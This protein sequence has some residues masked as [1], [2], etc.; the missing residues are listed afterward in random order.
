MKRTL[1]IAFAL[2]AVAL[3]ACMGDFGATSTSFVD[4]DARTPGDKTAV[5]GVPSDPSRENTPGDNSVNGAGT[6]VYEG[7]LVSPPFDALDGDND[8]DGDHVGPVP[9]STPLSPRAPERP[10]TSA[11]GGIANNDLE[12]RDDSP[13]GPT[14]DTGDPAI[15][16]PTPGGLVG[17]TAY[18]DGNNV[19]N[20]NNEGD[21]TGTEPDT[22]SGVD[23]RATIIVG[24]SGAVPADQAAAATPTPTASEALPTAAT[25][26]DYADGREAAILDA[27]RRDGRFTTLLRAFTQT[28]VP[29]FLAGLGSFT[30]FAPTDAAFAALPANEQERLWANPQLLR[31]RLLYHVSNIELEPAMIGRTSSM[32]TVTS[33]EITLAIIDGDLVLNNSSRV[34][35]A[36]TPV[37][38]GLIYPIDAVLV[39]QLP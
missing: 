31:E 24:Q 14:P 25:I 13:V 21:A 10:S 20:D 19:T 7:P 8:T 32:Q 2:L 15:A 4:G 27:L 28:D 29:N 34:L 16:V 38:R 18:A 22:I 26:A 37:A 33:G 6:G 9:T 30:L 36:G 39:P 11:I 17:A 23:L 5:A 3:G 12:Q 1:I 35:E